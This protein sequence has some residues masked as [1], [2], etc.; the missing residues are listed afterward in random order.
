MADRL[1]RPKT[2][3]F[4]PEREFE[5]HVGFHLGRAHAVMN[6]SFLD[7][8]ADLGLNPRAYRVLVTVAR[9]EG[10]HA[11]R[12]GDLIGV[13]RTNLVPVLTALEAE[14]LLLRHPDGQDGRIQ[15]LEPTAKARALLPTLRSRVEQ[16]EDRVLHALSAAEREALR[17]MLRRIWTAAAPD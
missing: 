1:N 4:S 17:D 5:D 10:L 11:S 3:R 9:E 16:H 15:R 14:G 8:F 13:K 2:A 12:L 7:A 6:A